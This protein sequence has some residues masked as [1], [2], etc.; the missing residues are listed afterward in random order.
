MQQN[1]LESRID[2]LRLKR[3]NTKNAFVNSA[4]WFLF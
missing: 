2:R 3:E 1:V 4:K